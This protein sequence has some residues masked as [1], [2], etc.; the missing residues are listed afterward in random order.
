MFHEA[1]FRFLYLLR[2]DI[3]DH[4]LYYILHIVDPKG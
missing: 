3:I 4:Y 1:L 2:V